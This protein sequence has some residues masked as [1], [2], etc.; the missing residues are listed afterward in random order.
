MALIRGAGNEG[1]ELRLI[2]IFQANGIRG[3]RRRR[4]FP[5]KPDFVFPTHRLAVFVDGCFWHGCPTHATWP[6]NNGAF[7]RTKIL[8]NRKRDRAVNRLLR[9]S[10]WRVLRIWEHALTRK[11]EAR[12]VRRLLAVL[13]R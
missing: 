6:K 1:T 5:G 4:K 8:A 7:W 12:T 10:G 13:R 9:K 2:R 11:Q 3:W